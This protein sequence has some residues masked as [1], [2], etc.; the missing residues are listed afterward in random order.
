ML[1]TLDRFVVSK[2]SLLGVTSEDLIKSVMYFR[3]TDF[4]KGRDK[5]KAFD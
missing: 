3:C 5:P 2:K 4:A 1:H